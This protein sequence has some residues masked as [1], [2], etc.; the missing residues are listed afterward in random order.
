[1]VD[2]LFIVKKIAGELLGPLSIGLFI[3]AAGFVALY[4]GRIKAAKTLLPL[5]FVWIALLSYAPVSDLLLKPLERQY[6]ALIETPVNVDYILVLGSGHNSDKALPI[7]SQVTTT[8]LTRLSEG[9]R[10]YNRLAD[11]KLVV[12][13]YGGQDPYNH[14]SM[15]KKAARALGVESDDIIMLET[16]KDT[17]E[18]AVAMKKMAGEKPFILVTSAS[19]MPRAFKIFK[20]QGLNPIA[21]PTGYQVRGESEWLQMP[22]GRSLRGSDLAF[23]EYLGLAWE[24]VK[25]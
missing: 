15:Q 19:H 16:P 18:E 14:A 10:H 21:A 7:T 2:T 17:Y 4:I 11:V 8:A 13:G 24:W 9:I 1:M 6:P 22:N 3:A 20:A 23:H 5:A 25:Q 12:S